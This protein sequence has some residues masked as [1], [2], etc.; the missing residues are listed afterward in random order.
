MVCVF[1]RETTG[2]LTSLVKQIDSEIA[3]DKSLKAFVVVPTDATAK[4][5]ESLKALAKANGIKNVPLTLFEGTAGPPDYHIAR[6]A[7]V[8]VMMWKG[9]K[10]QA[11]HAFAKG[12]MTEADVKTIM[13]D[14]SK[15][16]GD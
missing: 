13:A 16:T 4:T 2:P 5:S 14:L 3:K 6:D 7:D 15:I 11:N 12:K 1:A 9:G 8:T 10:V